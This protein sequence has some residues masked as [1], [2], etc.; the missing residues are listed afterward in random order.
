MN[1]KGAFFVIKVML[2]S[3]PTSFKYIKYVKF[4]KYVILKIYKLLVLIPTIYIF[5]H[6]KSNIFVFLK[7]QFC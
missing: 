1:L 3:V 2:S 5:F 4:I 7:R 6:E